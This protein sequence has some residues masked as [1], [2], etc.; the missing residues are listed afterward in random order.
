MN[1]NGWYLHNR[2]LGMPAGLNLYD[3]P[4]GDNFHL[5]WMK[6]VSLLSFNYDITFNIYFI[7]T[8]PLTVMTSLFVLHQFNVSTLPAIVGNLLFAFLPYHFL[9]GQEHFF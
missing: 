5:V 1:S 2:Y 4:V 8:L 3:F 9:R 6:L 7:L